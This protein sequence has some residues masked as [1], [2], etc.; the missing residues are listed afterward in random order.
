M[1]SS[2]GPSAA[3]AAAAVSTLSV[4]PEKLDQ[5]KPVRSMRHEKHTHGSSEV[6]HSPSS[7]SSSPRKIQ[8]SNFRPH[9]PSHALLVD[10]QC[11]PAIVRQHC[12]HVRTAAYFC[13]LLLRTMIK[14]CRSQCNKSN[15]SNSSHCI[16]IASKSGFDHTSSPSSSSRRRPIDGFLGRD[17]AFAT[18][19]TRI[20]MYAFAYADR[21]PCLTHPNCP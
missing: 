8:G 15:T 2:T 16:T 12:D 4:N 14:E 10:L 11:D 1:D 21:E 5:H 19:A 9:P 17:T 20:G 13:N 3:A 7:S 6:H 18:T